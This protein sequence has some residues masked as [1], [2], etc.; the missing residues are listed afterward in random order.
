MECPMEVKC[1]VSLLAPVYL[2]LKHETQF[3][4]HCQISF[5]AQW[6]F[7]SWRGNCSQAQ[8]TQA[9]VPNISNNVMWYTLH[10]NIQ[11]PLNLQWS[12][13]LRKPSLCL[14]Y[15][16]SWLS[17]SILERVGPL[18]FW[19]CCWFGA[20]V[21]CHCLLYHNSI[22]LNLASL[23]KKIKICNKISTTQYHFCTIFELACCK[24]KMRDYLCMPWS[25]LGA[26]TNCFR[27]VD[28]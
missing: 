13:I 3:L 21:H 16:T 12:H 5:Y 15:W 22:I 27:L 20:A 28:L 6:T 2:I 17:H 10:C 23:E 26:M 4:L 7:C 9:P 24:S 19:S 25:L 11:M 18:P 14:T 8:G 1:Q